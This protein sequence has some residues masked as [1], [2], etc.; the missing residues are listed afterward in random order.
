M[1]QLEES[2]L[3]EPFQEKKSEQLGIYCQRLE[4]TSHKET[5][6]PPFTA[7][8]PLSPGVGGYR[9]QVS[10]VAT[11][12]SVKVF[13]PSG[14]FLLIVTVMSASRVTNTACIFFFLCRHTSLCLVAAW[15][16]IHLPLII[17]GHSVLLTQNPEK[18]REQRVCQGILIRFSWNTCT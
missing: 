7:Q 4:P 13:S 15:R 6:S 14:S 12:Q 8:V 1:T 5:F 2:Q 18:T 10:F 9:V 11:P 16:E 17:L 3:P